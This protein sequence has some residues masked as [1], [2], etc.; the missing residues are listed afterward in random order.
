MRW[1]Q[2]RV[3]DFPWKRP[4]ERKKRADAKKKVVSDWKV[5]AASSKKAGFDLKFMTDSY[6]QGKIRT[7]IHLEKIKKEA[8]EREKKRIPTPTRAKEYHTELRA[9]I[10]CNDIGKRYRE[11]R[12]LEAAWGATAEELSQRKS[13]FEMSFYNSFAQDHINLTSLTTTS[14]TSNNSN[15]IT[16]D[17]PDVT[18]SNINYIN[19][20][21]I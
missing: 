10:E 3:G 21:N 20:P 14:Y 12:E 8:F 5:M 1:N 18:W 16:L 11:I 13:T 4:S 7:K 6:E 2:T 17:N 19:P 9:L 15:Y